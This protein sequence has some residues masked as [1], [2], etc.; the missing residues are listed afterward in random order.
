MGGKIWKQYTSSMIRKVAEAMVLKRIAGISGLVTD[1]EMDT[2]I[3][4]VD[5]EVI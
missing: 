3:Q 5:A 2:D 4:I 1:A